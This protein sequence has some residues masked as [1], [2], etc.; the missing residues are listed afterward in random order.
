MTGLWQRNQCFATQTSIQFQVTA[1]PE[2]AQESGRDALNQG[3]RTGSAA[4]GGA[5]RMDGVESEGLQTA[6]AGR[7][8]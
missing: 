3:K 4:A 8:P 7:E 6:T 1:G 2:Q 5:P